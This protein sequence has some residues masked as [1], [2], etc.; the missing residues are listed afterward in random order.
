MR[1]DSSFSPAR[2]TVG[3]P[4]L[5]RIRRGRSQERR[6]AGPL[7]KA[8]VGRPRRRV[9]GDVAEQVSRRSLEQLGISKVLTMRE[10]PLPKGDSQV[11]PAGCPK[12]QSVA[13]STANKAQNVDAYWRCSTCGHIW[14]PARS[15]RPRRRTYL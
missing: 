2:D 7:I 5:S 4:F 15:E 11:M 9:H 13:V 6:A 1:T 10:V 8:S 14:N 12:C 3:L